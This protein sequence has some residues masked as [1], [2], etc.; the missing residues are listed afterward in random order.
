MSHPL[1]L[2]LAG[3][4]LLISLIGAIVIAKKKV[5][6]EGAAISR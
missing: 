1:G 6:D 4:I 2:E 5:P 3:V